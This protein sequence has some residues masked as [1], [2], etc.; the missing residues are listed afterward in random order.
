MLP[1]AG[2][3]LLEHLVD[4]LRSYGITELA[5][6]LHYL[7]QV[8][9]TH[10]GA[11]DGYGVTV[12]YSYE[13]ELLGTAG[14]AKQLAAFLDEPFVVVYGD[15]FTNVNLQ[16]L[17]DSHTDRR[18][19]GVSI[20]LALYRVSNPTECG[21]VELDNGGR[22]QRF[23]EKP[24]AHQVFTDLANAGIL[25]CEPSVLEWIPPATPFDFGRD[26]L[27]RLL[28]AGHPVYGVTINSDEF[29]FDIGTIA[30]LARAQEA[31]ALV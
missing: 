22:V 28:D 19:I 1:L 12:T 24:P 29:V 5:M 4:W 17:I 9:T 18:R 26:L 10:F 8:I 13:P 2:K 11:G 20:T 16:R 25:V 14:A 30:G 21:L 23:V 15:L 31:L 27:P 7:P 3:P 6:N